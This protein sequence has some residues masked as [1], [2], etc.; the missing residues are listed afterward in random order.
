MKALKAVLVGADPEL[1]EA[2]AGL[3]RAALL[4]RCAEL[5][6]PVST[7]D[8]GMP[9]A[10]AYI[11]AARPPHPAPGRRGQ[12]T[13][14]RASPTRSKP[15]PR[16]CST[17]SASA[18]TAPPPCSSPPA[19]TPTGFATRRPSPHCAG[20]ARSRRP[21]ARPTGIGSTA[22]AT[23]KPTPPSTAS[24]SPVHAATDAPATTSTGAS[25]KARPSR[26]HPLPQALHRP[27]DPEPHPTSKNTC[28]HRRESPTRRRLTNIGAS[29][30]LHLTLLKQALIATLQPSGT[31]SRS[32]QRPYD[33]RPGTTQEPRSA[34]AAASAGMVALMCC[35]PAS[36]PACIRGTR[37]GSRCAGIRVSCV[38]SVR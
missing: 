36:A 1:R 20:P 32:N 24:R 7:D 28:R 38:S 29:A 15:T 14:P 9:A 11:A 19:T 8:G 4:R 17:V 25:G 18:R 6:E 10:V 16:S 27:R 26:S 35:R 37:R 2:M 22:A 31:K 30:P 5:P 34:H 13:S 23:G 21:P 12:R 3:G 33:R